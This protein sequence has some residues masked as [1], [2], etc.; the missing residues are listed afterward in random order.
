MVNIFKGV[1]IFF[2]FPPL[3][4]TNAEAIE[5]EGALEKLY[6]VYF[7]ANIERYRGGLVSNE[8]AFRH[9]NS[10]VVIKEDEF[11]F[12]DRAFYG[13]P[14][15]DI[16]VHAIQNEEGNVPRADERF[17]NFYGYGQE[18]ENIRT[19]TVDGKKL[20]EPPYIFEVVEDMLWFFSDGWFYRLEK[21]STDDSPLS[22][23]KNADTC[24]S[25]Q[26]QG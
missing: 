17:G 21:H 10:L 25:N 6:G 23:N 9:L 22:F 16:E 15:Y 18:R 20:N 13:K 19:L 26:I 11:S 1:I 4:F 12:L 2:A 8:E 5:K 24:L 14:I 3:V 7:V